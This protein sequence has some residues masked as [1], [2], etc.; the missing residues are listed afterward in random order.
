[1]WVLIGLMAGGM[2][3]LHHRLKR[4]ESQME[5][6]VRARGRIGYEKEED[7]EEGQDEDGEDEDGEDEGM[8]TL[9]RNDRLS[10][11]REGEEEGDEE[12]EE[13]E[14]APP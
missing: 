3:F 1:M 12:E 14:E 2:Y 10:I 4:M 6:T 13:E 5:E 7:E 9:E 11:L 8:V